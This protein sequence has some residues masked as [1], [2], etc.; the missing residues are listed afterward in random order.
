MR[1][2]NLLYLFLGLNVALAGAFVTYLFL[3]SNSQP[4]VVSTSFSVPAKTNQARPVAVATN[5]AKNAQTS[6]ATKVPPAAV[7][8]AA[9]VAVSTNATLA[10][11]PVF[12][13]KKFTWKEVESPEYVSYISSLRAVGCPEEKVRT[14]VL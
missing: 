9:N 2:R 10:A 8:N 5:L 1:D 4:K 14:I 7:T 6:S 13:D 12:T 3:S 11:K